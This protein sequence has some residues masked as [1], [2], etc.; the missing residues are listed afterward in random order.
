MD[1]KKIAYI[2]TSVAALITLGIGFDAMEQFNSTGL[3]MLILAITPYMFMSFVVSK[4][5]HSLSLTV[6]AWLTIFLTLWG[7]ATLAYE[8]FIHKDAQSA[9][10]F[11]VIPVY[12]LFVFAIVSFIVYLIAKRKG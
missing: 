2:F 12:Q 5:E 4:S 10:S 8:M 9:I 6:N 1:L 11:V 3:I 7:T